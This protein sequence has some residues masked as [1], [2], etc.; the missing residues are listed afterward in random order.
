MSDTKS[1]SEI[2]VLM[3]NLIQQIKK[4]N[5]WEVFR[6]IDSI[7]IKIDYAPEYYETFGVIRDDNK[8]VFGN[9][10]DII[11]PKAVSEHLWE[12]ILIRE[13]FGFF[14]KEEILFGEIKYLTNIFLNIIA[15]S[16]LQEKISE[17]AKDIKF[18]PIQSRFLLPPN[19]DDSNQLELFAKIGSLIEIINQG[20]TYKLLYNTYINFI[21]DVP[22]EEIEIDE[23]LNDVYRY[24]SNKPEE[25]AAP[26]TLKENTANVL[27]ELV[28]LG[29]N[30][31]TSE[32]AKVLGVNQSTIARQI[33][34]ISSKFY[35]R[36]RLEKNYE[37]L[38]LHSY[39][40]LI[41]IPLSNE[42]QL[43]FVSEELLK[44]S[45]FQQYYEGRGNECFYQ[46]SILHC[47]HI[48]AIRIE[49]KLEKLVK[50]KV[51]SS[52]EVKE[53]FDRIFSTTIVNKTFKPTISNFKQLLNKKIPYKRILLFNNEYHSNRVREIF[54]EKDI[55]LFKFISIIIS[56]TASKYGLFGTH[57]QYLIDFFEENGLDLN[58]QPECL[59]FINRLQ[60]IA[61]NRGI[62]TYRFNI[63]LSGIAN[64]DLLIIRLI[65]NSNRDTIK[66]FLDKVSCFG[67]TFLG[68]TLDENYLHILGPNYDH[69]L[70]K[71][72]EEI[73]RKNKIKFE[74]FSVKVKTFRYVDYSQLYDFQSQ[75]FI[76]K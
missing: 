40:L 58:N 42:N 62:F 44:V 69:F 76:P 55:Q 35:A 9:W 71:L 30:T 48:V 53:I 19:K 31:S 10:I 49:N 7:E 37:K 14:F 57:Y 72:I 63:S 60:N 27:S 22:F 38:G 59:T 51:I 23:V 65:E 39:I 15:L 50:N 12:F 16:F 33:A 28:R 52:Y 1:P 13:S 54:D 3:K 24:L 11:E 29:F 17:S 41:R 25:I 36:W 64:S 75:K 66:K 2:K 73:I 70:T 67:W 21:E 8:I 43:D 6:E 5:K 45:Y 4:E 26:I 61:Y 20:T 32:L 56:K 18:F 34:K 74:I 46:Y 68:I 47:P